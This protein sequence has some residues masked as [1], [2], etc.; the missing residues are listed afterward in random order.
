MRE[1]GRGAPPPEPR[2]L[3]TPSRGGRTGRGTEQ[4]RGR[5]REA[6]Y[7]G[8]AY[9]H[10]SAIRVRALSSRHFEPDPD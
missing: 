8:S 6:K 5:R 7:P 4:G 10:M 3:S 9:S 1:V 2:T